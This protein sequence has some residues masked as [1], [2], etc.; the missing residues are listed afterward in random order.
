MSQ[1]DDGGRKEIRPLVLGA[2]GLVGSRLAAHL[3]GPF[4][5]TIAA[6]RAEIDITDRWRTEA[7]IER[8]EPTVV[9]NCAAL[10][11]VDLCEREPGLAMTVNAEAPAGLAA[12][13]RNAGLRLVHFST[14][15]VFDGEKDGEYDEAD[16]PAPVNEYGRSKLHGEMG[17]L[18]TLA[19]AVVV[20][21]SF[22]FGPGRPT[23]LDKIA[24][25][26]RSGSGPIPVIDGWVSR[27]TYTGDIAAGVE[28]IVRSDV[29]GLW[30]LACPPAASR[31]AFAREVLRAAGADPD[32]IVP[33]DPGT[34]R[35]D[36]KRPAS[37][38]LS[39]RRLEARFGPVVRPWT[40]H[41]ARYFASGGG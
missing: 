4:P 7:E 18:E 33:V 31:A 9:I 15:Y 11:D 37:S 36:A 39:T 16:P 35:L 32:R 40:D 1:A 6:T 12:A 2:G 24:G 26:A 27:P 17:V 41:L 13:C 38:A 30:H 3:E 34:L 19:D 22:V 14:D 21:I 20:R 23:F 28:A 8:L 29:T 25:Q 5:R 10:S